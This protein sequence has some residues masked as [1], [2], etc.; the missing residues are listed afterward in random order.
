[1]HGS[2]VVTPLLLSSHWQA[3]TFTVKLF[4][5]PGHIRELEPELELGYR[6]I[7]ASI[8]VKHYLSTQVFCLHDHKL[9]I[10]V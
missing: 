10:C 8:R 9:N 1:M 7:L 5:G 4:W 2:P 6:H 3:E